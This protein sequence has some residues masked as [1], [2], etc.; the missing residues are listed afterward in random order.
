MKTR[1]VFVLL[2]AVS[3]ALAQAP[4]PESFLGFKVGEDRK[5]ADWGQV[6]TLMKKAGR[7]VNPAYCS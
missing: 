3:S 6:E 1:L 7:R 2:L 4:S 5:M